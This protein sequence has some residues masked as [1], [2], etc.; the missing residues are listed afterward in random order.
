ML[1]GYRAIALLLPAVRIVDAKEFGLLSP[2]YAQPLMYQDKCREFVLCHF[3]ETIS[4]Y[5]FKIVL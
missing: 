5:A 1:V 2:K 4:C 3:G